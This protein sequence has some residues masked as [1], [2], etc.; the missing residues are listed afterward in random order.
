MEPLVKIWD[1]VKVIDS[2]C[3]LSYSLPSYQTDRG[4]MPRL[5]RAIKVTMKGKTIPVATIAAHEDLTQLAI[6][7]YDGTVL[8]MKGDLSRDRF[9]NKPFRYTSVP[10]MPPNTD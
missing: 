3:Q 10:H 1:I 5:I 2:H 8:L 7:L 6:G 4:G 9:S